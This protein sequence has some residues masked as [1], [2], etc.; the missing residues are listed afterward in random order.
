MYLLPCSWT[1]P[2]GNGILSGLSVNLWQQIGHSAVAVVKSALMHGSVH[3]L[4]CAKPLSLLPTAT[5]FMSP[6]DKDR[7]SCKNRFTHAHRVDYRVLRC[8]SSGSCGRRSWEV[9]TTS[10]PAASWTQTICSSSLLP[11]PWNVHS[12]CLPCTRSCPKDTVLREKRVIEPI[13]TVYMTEPG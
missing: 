12:A 7:G 1:D 11:R 3:S 4:A 9:V 8:C 5:L 10:W 6:L 2:P 13:W